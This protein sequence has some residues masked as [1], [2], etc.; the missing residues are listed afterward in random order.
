MERRAMMKVLADMALAGD[1]RA[2]RYL[3]DYV[4]RNPHGQ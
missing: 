4:L 3:C 2:I 1:M